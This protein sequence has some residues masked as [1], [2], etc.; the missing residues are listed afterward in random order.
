[1]DTFICGLKRLKKGAIPF[2]IFCNSDL[3]CNSL[4]KETNQAKMYTGQPMETS[5][6]KL[7]RKF[8]EEP[9]VPVGCLVTAGVLGGGLRSFAKAADSRTQQKFMRARV[10]AQGAT[11]LAVA[12]GS[13]IALQK[14]QQ[15]PVS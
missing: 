15:K 6:E 11:V 14:K 2:C 8:K 1:M 5:M 9:F 10:F 4:A 7:K 12:V 3:N 13:F